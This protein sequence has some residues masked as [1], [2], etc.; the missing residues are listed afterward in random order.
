MTLAA[1]LLLMSAPVA[2]AA[3]CPADTQRVVAEVRAIL[4]MPQDA[5]FSPNERAALLCLADAVGMLDRK[6][7]DL[8][9][10]KLEFTGPVVSP[11]GFA[12][13]GDNAASKEDR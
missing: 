13:Q 1:A 9:A 4:E 7:N 6:L 2:A 8:I 10:G 12:A 5:T 3:D 11:K